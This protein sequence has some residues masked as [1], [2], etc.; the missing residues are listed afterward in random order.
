MRKPAPSRRASR[1]VRTSRYAGTYVACARACSCEVC[2]VTANCSECT[3]AARPVSCRRPPRSCHAAT[4]RAFF[5]SPGYQE[6]RRL[7]DLSDEHNAAV[8]AVG[9]ASTV[10][11][12]STAVKVLYVRT[13]IMIILYI[14][15]NMDDTYGHS[16][17][18]SRIIRCASPRSAP[19]LSD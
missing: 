19:A 14:V 17:S 6:R 3:S 8:V 16:V 2:L 4:R 11:T 1:A 5:V 18:R 13:Y 7:D 9:A 15:Y 10:R 12:A